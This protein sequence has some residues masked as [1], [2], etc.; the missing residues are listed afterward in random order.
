MSMEIVGWRCGSMLMMEQEGFLEVRR[1]GR[2]NRGWE[3][4]RGRRER[5]HGGH[6]RN[7]VDGIIR[8]GGTKE[9]LRESLVE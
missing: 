5:S 2:R 6:G 1:V 4:G 8:S 9:S 3:Q 7:L